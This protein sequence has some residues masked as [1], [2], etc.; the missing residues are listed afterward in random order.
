[1]TARTVAALTAVIIIGCGDGWEEFD[2]GVCK[3]VPYAGSYVIL[4]EPTGIVT[5][6]ATLMKRG[7]DCQGWTGK[8]VERTY[9]AN[10]FEAFYSQVDL[11]YYT[12]HGLPGE[13]ST[14][15][16]MMGLQQPY[17]RARWVI[18]SACLVLSTTSWIRKE[19]GT[20]LMGYD[21][22]LQDYDSYRIAGSLLRAMADGV[23]FPAAFIEANEDRGVYNWIVVD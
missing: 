11:V 16:G 2:S 6:D 13:I 19:D 17:F 22:V 9:K 4:V 21:A 18:L 15:D 20:T 5:E 3:P 10:A 23:E 7:L 1:M 12:G 14:A 8:V